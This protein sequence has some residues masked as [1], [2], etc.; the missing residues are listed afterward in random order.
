[1]I[2]K[3]NAFPPALLLVLLA[4]VAPAQT[5]AP[6][7]T[8]IPASRQSDPVCAAKHA[9]YV[10]E[11]KGNPDLIFLGDS[12]TE[13]WSGNGKDAWAKHYGSMKA[14]QFGVSADR[15]QNV[16]W[17]VKNGEIDQ[18]KVVVLLVGTNNIWDN[19]GTQI[20]AGISAIIQE[21]QQRSPQTKFLLLGVFPR[22][23]KPG[24]SER[25]NVARMN[26]E[27][28]KLDDRKTVFYLDIGGKFLEPDGTL[29]K[30]M[31]GDFLHPTA[32]GYEIWA[33]AIQDQLDSL[34]KS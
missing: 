19:P 10:E 32:K 29:S 16:L 33:E 5:A 12:I 18:P 24:T 11:T 30:D 25:D 20:A 13:L 17:R 3:K 15:V 27:I 26:A 1:M 34:M 28:A 21:I 2:L 23:E 14:A 8:L 9:R 31:M 4:S 6:Y 7:P 22:G